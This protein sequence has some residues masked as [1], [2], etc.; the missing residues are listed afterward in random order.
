[1]SKRLSN[2]E[3]D[4]ISICIWEMT[5]APYSISSFM[6]VIVFYLVIRLPAVTCL[7]FS[8]GNPNQ[9]QEIYFHFSEMWC[10]NLLLR[11]SFSFCLSHMC[12]H[13]TQN[14]LRVSLTCNPGVKKLYDSFSRN[15]MRTFLLVKFFALRIYMSWENNKITRKSDKTRF[16]SFL[17]RDII[18]LLIKVFVSFTCEPNLSAC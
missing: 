17:K 11:L 18:L 2:I 8:L 16:F 7:R 9:P 13:H 15:E 12:T 6:G 14:M 4:G 3:D 1:M 10:F 5:S